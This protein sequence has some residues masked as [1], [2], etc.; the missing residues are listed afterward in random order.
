MRYSILISSLIVTLTAFGVN[1][2]P[3]AD[4][5]VM[6]IRRFALK[7]IPTQNEQLTEAAAYARSLTRRRPTRRS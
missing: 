7:G 5:Q 3:H 1:A 4:T 2:T 6:H